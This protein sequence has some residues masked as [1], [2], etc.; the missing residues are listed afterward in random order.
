VT[1]QP[2]MARPR[3]IFFVS[4]VDVSG[5]VSKAQIVLFWSGGPAADY[6]AEVNPRRRPL[7]DAAF[8]KLTVIYHP[9]HG[10]GIGYTP[11][12]ADS[13]LAHACTCGT[14]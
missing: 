10:P 9:H 8:V 12:V 5:A 14:T 3:G 4:R 7:S 13:G 6:L 2:S 11:Y 1:Q